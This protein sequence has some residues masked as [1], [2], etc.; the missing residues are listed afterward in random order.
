M[1]ALGLLVAMVVGLLGRFW[2]LADLSTHFSMYFAVASVLWVLLAVYMRRRKTII[3]LLIILSVNI[4]TVL[5][6]F[7]PR[8]NQ[9]QTQS[10]VLSLAQFNILHKN[11]DRKQALDFIRN[12]DADIMFIQEI[13]PWWAG[14]VLESDV[15]YRFEVSR[16]ADG[17]FG[18]AMLVHTSID[19]DDRVVIE[20]TRV[21]DYAEGVDGVERPAIEA[22]LLLD[23]QRVKLLSIH[24]P[25]PTRSEYFTLRNEI[26]QQAR[27][28]ADA[29]TDPHVVIGDLN[30][31]PW[32][33]AFSIL[34]KGGG[35]VSTL[36]GRGN[37]GTWP[38]HLPMPWLLP[39]DHC[40]HSVEWDCV[41]REI[42]PETGSDHLPLL[43]SLVLRSGVLAAPEH[44][45][46]V[47]E[48]FP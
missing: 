23:G 18:I 43:V 33:H 48:T 4:W 32:S 44:P 35:L 22:T 29:Q 8:G 12:C 45:A 15:P 40:L 26:L 17:S 5:P 36:D 2:W 41:E 9:V 11:R 10:P 42:G 1:G 3:I 46:V 34:T 47:T 14:V 39:I 19:S 37:Q 28:W 16:P 30:T 38:T 20:G 21:I 25:P 27:D 13:D 24:P 6:S 7:L 31:T